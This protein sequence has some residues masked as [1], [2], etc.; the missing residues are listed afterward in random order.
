MIEGATKDKQTVKA[1]GTLIRE[2]ID[3]VK[4]R[5]VKNILTR[6]GGV[7]TELY[8]EDWGVGPKPLRHVIHV[9]LQPGAISAW[10]CHELQTDSIFAV[11]GQL[12]LA[13][14]DDREKS[15]T[16][17]RVMVLYIGLNRPSLVDIPP[18]VW[19]GLQNVTSDVASFV[20]MFD[21]AYNYENPDEW[22]LPA[23]SPKIPYKF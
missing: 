3:G 23:D 17:G 18:G 2:T 21:Y 15:P 1:D 19:H 16:R 11:R 14:Y 4:I 9:N 22:R 7:T 5:E 6:N 8:R 13:L 10:H 20:N 12:K